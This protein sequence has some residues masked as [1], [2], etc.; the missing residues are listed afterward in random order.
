MAIGSHFQ[1]CVFSSQPPQRILNA[2]H[3]LLEDNK[4]RFVDIIR[5]KAITRKS[6]LHQ[7]YL[8]LASMPETYELFDGDNLSLIGRREIFSGNI[9]VREPVPITF[10]CVER[11]LELTE[12]GIYSIFRPEYVALNGGV[13]QYYVPGIQHH[14]ASYDGV[15]LWC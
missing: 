8:T 2:I 10:A 14:F 9:R 5:L 4:F 12:N 1:Y 6:S 3:F 11:M 7:L 13:V 15:K